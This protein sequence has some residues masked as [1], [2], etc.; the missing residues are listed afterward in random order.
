M[1]GVCMVLLRISRR[2]ERTNIFI[3]LNYLDREIFNK[4]PTFLT[5][6]CS[7]C[8]FGLTAILQPQQLPN[9]VHLRIFLF[10]GA[11]GAK[12]LQRL[13]ANFRAQSCSHSFRVGTE[14]S[15]VSL[16]SFPTCVIIDEIMPNSRVSCSSTKW[17]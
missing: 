9:K 15:S 14:L 6:Y 7:F 16:F 17:S 2:F 11:F 3:V 1:I 10:H 8:W 4:Y 13:R 12:V 5:I